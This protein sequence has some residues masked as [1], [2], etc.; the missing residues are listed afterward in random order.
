MKSLVLLSL[1]FL[2]ACAHDISREIA[3]VDDEFLFG[4]IDFKRSSIQMFPVTVEE[5]RHHYT[6]F[7]QLKDAHDRFIDIEKKELFVKAA[8]GVVVNH[9]L[10]RSQRGKY[11]ITIDSESKLAHK[12]LV[13]L[14]NNKAVNASNRLKW[15]QPSRKYST[16]VQTRQGINRRSFKL[17]LKS[18]A[19]TFITDPVVPEIIID[20]YAEVEELKKDP[21]GCWDFEVTY[22][23]ENQL[24]FISVR[25]HGA[26]FEQM[27]RI[28]HVE[29]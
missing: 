28:H 13:F 5:G 3:S 9:V 4:E 23:D 19:K 15:V 27:I 24:F 20:G 17:C 2:G 11:Y 6:F 18:D 21:P 8:K 10:D 26:Y 14:L 1:I 7:L 29:K 22:P 12:E 16:L 25:S